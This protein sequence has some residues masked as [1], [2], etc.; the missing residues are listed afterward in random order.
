MENQTP[1]LLKSYLISVVCHVLFFSALLFSP[2][3]AP[4]KP[5][6]PPVID[7]SMVSTLE[8]SSSASSKPV[9]ETKDPKPV[10]KAP[11]PAPKPAE[12]APEPAAIPKEAVSIAPAKPK[13]KTSLKKETMK[14]TKVVERAIKKIEKKVASEP[15]EPVSQAL[16]RLRE[17]VS[18]EEKSGQME[19]PPKS[20]P[21]AAGEGQEGKTGSGGKKQGDLID[22][23]RLE[24]AYS[25]Q[26]NWAFAEQ[27][28]GDEEDL[29]ASLYF[30]VMPS[31]EIRDITFAD[32][33]GNQYLDDSAY[34]AIAK[35][36]PVAP[37]PSGIHENF[38][39]VGIRF[40][41][42]GLK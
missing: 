3:F 20:E 41:P 30:K 17:K 7:V 18:Q 24:V 25:I 21:G 6:M 10:A 37:H 15:A 38:V 26:K 32:R 23:Y 42:Q 16:E 40:G 36:N 39:I 29:Q 33:S 8:P 13:A 12:A 14:P 22:L 4:D 9:A 2:R 5:F 28:A 19:S 11:E 34:K 35:S 1:S 31:G 27:L